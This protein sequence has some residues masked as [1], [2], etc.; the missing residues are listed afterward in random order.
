VWVTCHKLLLPV[1][2]LLPAL[3]LSVCVATQ[4]NK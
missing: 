4:R 3:S 1:L 2:L